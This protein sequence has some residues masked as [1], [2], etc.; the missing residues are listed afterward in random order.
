MAA[1]ATAVFPTL[2][3]VALAMAVFP[4]L[5][6]AVYL[7]TAVAL[8][9]A[10][11]LETAAQAMA[12]FLTL[13]M[14]ALAIAVFPILVLVVDLGMVV[15]QAMAQVPATVVLLP[16]QATAVSQARVPATPLGLL[17]ILAVVE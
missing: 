5:V 11:V 6:T 1:P 17:E 7:A 12:A 4:I 13:E 16:L 10:Q 3:M 9:A 8:E 15:T 14:A 2:V